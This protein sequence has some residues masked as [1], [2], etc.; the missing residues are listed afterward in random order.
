MEATIQNKSPSERTAYILFDNEAI[1]PTLVEL[2]VLPGIHTFQVNFVVKENAAVETYLVDVVAFEYLR[3]DLTSQKTI[4]LSVTDT[5]T[6]ISI[7]LP[8]LGIQGED[9]RVNVTLTSYSIENET[10]YLDF[11][12]SI[13][14]QDPSPLEVKFGTHTYNVIL[15]IKENEPEGFASFQVNITRFNQSIYLSPLETLEVTPALAIQFGP[16]KGNY[17]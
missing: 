2:V 15:T 10:I 4:A 12:E 16:E 6:D 5:I 9:I 3:N 7:D 8:E 1:D 14:D 11:K 17:D 13:F